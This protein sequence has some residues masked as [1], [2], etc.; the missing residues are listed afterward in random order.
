MVMILAK[1]TSVDN[2]TSVLTPQ[3]NNPSCEE[4]Y[5]KLTDDSGECK[6]TGNTFV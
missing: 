6:D 5:N 4:A 3:P 1:N 2:L